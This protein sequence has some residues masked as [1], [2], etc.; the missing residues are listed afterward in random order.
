MGDNRDQV[1]ARRRSG[2]RRALRARGADHGTPRIANDPN[3]SIDLT[4]FSMPDEPRPMELAEQRALAVSAHLRDHGI[5]ARR[6]LIRFSDVAPEDPFLIADAA[7]RT[8]AVSFRL[9]FTQK[10]Q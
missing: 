3:G 7:E 2:A 5:P 10:T 4:G 1:P 9:R 8:S 6:Q